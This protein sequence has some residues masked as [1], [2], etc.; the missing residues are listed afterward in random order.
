MPVFWISL[1]ILLQSRSPEVQASE[2]RLA[3]AALASPRPRE[4][5]GASGSADGLWLR[6][7]AGDAQ[8]Y[9]ELLARGYARLEHTPNDALAAAEAAQRVAGPLPVVLV[10][11]GRARLRLGQPAAA[12]EQFTQA[13]ARDRAAFAE[14]A[15]LHDYAKAASLEGQFPL[16]VRLYR[17]LASR[18]VLLADAREASFVQLEV[19][20]HVLAY[21]PDGADEALGYLAQAQR[22]SLGMSAWVAGLRQLV[23]VRSGHS[24]NARATEGLPRPQAFDA[25]LG[26]AHDAGPLLP[27]G[28]LDAMRA[29][30]SERNDPAAARQFWDSYL[31]HAS[32]ENI[33]TAEGRKRRAELGSSKE[34]KP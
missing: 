15:A 31:A 5:R 6:A 8:R 12:L 33:W 3:T 34:A 27:P 29:V 16:A 9:C 32:P 11:A 1:A 26:A 14:P 24:F 25:A 10:L 30:L 23:A 21:V 18:S 17:L 28:E 4:C 20:A 7:H 19:A 2:N 13:E 22:A